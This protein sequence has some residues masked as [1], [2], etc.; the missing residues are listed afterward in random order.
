LTPIFIGG[1][2]RSGT[3]LLGAMLGAHDRVVCLPE[4]PFIG[5]LAASLRRSAPTRETLARLHKDVRADFKF[6]FLNIAKA[7][8]EACAAAPAHSYAQVIDGYIGCFARANGKS[9]AC[10]WVDHSPT[11][12]MY[13]ARLSAEFPDAKFVHI[14]RDGRAVSASWIPLDWGPNTIASAAR[15]WVANVAYGLAAE[16]AIPA[17]KIR[18]VSYEALVTDP[19]RVLKQLCVWLGLPYQPSMRAGKGFQVPAYTRN[20]HDLIG[21]PASAA[22]I[23]RWRTNLTAREVEIFETITGDLLVNLGYELVTSGRNLEPSNLEK[24][25]ME[26][27]DKTRQL[28]HLAT[29]PIRLRRFLNSNE[30]DGAGRE[31]TTQEAT[32]S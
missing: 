20:Q 9:D 10:H 8:L 21:Q 7:D 11:N 1:C 23:D 24:I 22:R 26:L 28:A 30:R 27:V 14:V 16:G 17:A 5:M 19:D 18:R 13:N 4:A 15:T 25:R 31:S 29:R 32:G 6:A 12:I 3:T 2:P